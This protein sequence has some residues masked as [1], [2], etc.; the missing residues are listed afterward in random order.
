MYWTG[1]Y[2]CMRFS[3]E[4]GL[5]TMP[6]LCFHHLS[7]SWETQH[8]PHPEV[9]QHQTTSERACVLTLV[10]VCVSLVYAW[11]RDGWIEMFTMLVYL[12]VF[13]VRFL[14]TFPSVSSL[15]RS[16]GWEYSL[17]DSS[18]AYCIDRYS[19]LECICDFYW[20][21]SVIRSLMTM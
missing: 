12:F 16:P 3:W 6:S 15:C 19:Q 20:K 1:R 18:N 10:C 11:A 7:H 5:R 8:L 4:M 17:C 14:R 13:V 2:L 21:K 9:C